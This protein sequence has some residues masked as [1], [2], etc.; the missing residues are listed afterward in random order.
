[1]SA[2]DSRRFATAPGNWAVSIESESRHPEWDAFLAR[3]PGGDVNQTSAWGRLKHACGLA[4]HRLVLRLDGAVAGGAQLVARQMSGVGSV[5]YLPYGPVLAPSTPNPA[6]AALVRS[7]VDNCRQARIR[8]LFVQPPERG[9]RAAGAMRAA[10]FRSSDADVAPSASLR[11]DLQLAPDELLARMSRHSRAD[12]RRSQREPL[13]VRFATRDDLRAFHELHRHSADRQGFTPTPLAYLESMWDELHPEGWLEVLLV[14]TDGT[15]VAGTL[16]TRFGGVVTNRLRGFAHDR[17]PT[18]MRPNE[19]LTWAEIEWSRDCGVRWYDLGG[20]GVAEAAA[21]AAG[22]ERSSPQMLDS[23]A[24]HKIALGGTPVIYPEP[25]QLI[26]NGL[27]RTGYGALRSSG[28][29]RR[30][31]QVARAR[32]RAASRARGR[33]A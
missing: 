2:L 13:T 15:D 22:A 23:A 10:G 11:L 12:V 25:L 32:W 33:P 19:A 28:A 4:I 21:L 16:V 27:L 1:M 6:A 9:E 24:A 17:L 7:L 29:A 5:A 14:A 26:P 20:I 3:T 31:R 8:A 18:R 30:V